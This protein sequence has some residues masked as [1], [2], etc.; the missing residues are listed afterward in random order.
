MDDEAV[1]VDEPQPDQ[2]AGDRDAALD[3]QVLAGLGLQALDVGGQ[4][5]PEDAGVLPAWA[6]R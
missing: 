2:R 4:V 5:G 6:G 3:Q 1:L